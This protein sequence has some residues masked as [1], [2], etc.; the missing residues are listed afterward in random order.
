MRSWAARSRLAPLTPGRVLVGLA[1]AVLL[2]SCGKDDTTTGT[3]TSKPAETHSPSG[4]KSDFKP[5]PALESTPGPYGSIAVSA[6]GLHAGFAQGKGN[7]AQAR[8]SAV[9]TCIKAAKSTSAGCAEQLWFKESCGALATG[10]NGAFGTGWGDNGK[11]A[12]RWALQSCRDAG[13]MACRADYYACSPG[14][15]TGTCD[16]TFRS[17][18]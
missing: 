7:R 11:L 6:S 15:L 1:F 16:G 14:K 2:A 3:D 9:R 5:L 12:C 8:D 10:D 17:N 4:K 13:G 18:H